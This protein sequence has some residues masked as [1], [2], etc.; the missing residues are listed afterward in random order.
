MPG[1]ICWRGVWADPQWLRR[2]TMDD[3]VG[4]ALSL[5]HFG[6]TGCDLIAFRVDTRGFGTHDNP[7]RRLPLPAGGRDMV[8]L[9]MDVHR[10]A[11]DTDPAHAFLGAV[12][13]QHVRFDQATM[14][15][16]GLVSL[17]KVDTMPSAVAYCV[18]PDDVIGVS[19]TD[20]YSILAVAFKSAVLR[21]RE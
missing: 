5:Y 1:C 19:G 20:R 4:G 3:R 2:R 21:E 9:H 11:I 16:P 12:S 17:P 7:A 15:C 13:F 6:S 8:V 14:P 18:P 10:D